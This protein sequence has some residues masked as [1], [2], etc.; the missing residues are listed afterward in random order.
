MR[1]HDRIITFGVLYLD[2]TAA[3]KGGV[4]VGFRP[5]FS[6]EMYCADVV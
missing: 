5:R 1:D 2:A 6:N 3:C 4:L